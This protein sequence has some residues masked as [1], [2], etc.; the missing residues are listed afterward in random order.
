MAIIVL[1]TFPHFIIM[2]LAIFLFTGAI[3]MVVTH[4]PKNWLMLHKFLASVG[5]LTA[6]I[7]V[8]SL[9]GLVLEILHGI[10]GLIIV[11]IFIGIVFVGL[12]AIKKKDRKVRSAHI[13]ISRIIYVISLFLVILG[14]ITLL[15]L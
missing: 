5:V 13:L 12:I 8:L 11:I 1:F 3:I 4:K 2:L 15:Y 10:M 9:G 14:I 7:A 6:L